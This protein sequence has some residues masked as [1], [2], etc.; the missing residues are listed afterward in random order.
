M[1]FVPLIE[2]ADQVPKHSFRLTFLT[3]KK[4]PKLVFTQ[5]REDARRIRDF[6]IA[7]GAL[8]E[9]KYNLPGFLQFLARRQQKLGTTHF[10]RKLHI[11]GQKYFQTELGPGIAT[12]TCAA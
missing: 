12:T 2:M 7:L 11:E 5:T 9:I 6:C 3:K 1:D 8:N 10:A 4:E